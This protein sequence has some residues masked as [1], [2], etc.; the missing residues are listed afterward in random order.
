MRTVCVSRK[1]VKRDSVK[2]ERIW[3]MVRWLIR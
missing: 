1:N 3:G 2:Q